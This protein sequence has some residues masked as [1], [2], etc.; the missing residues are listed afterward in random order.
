MRVPIVPFALKCALD[1]FPRPQYDHFVDP[2][3]V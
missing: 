3:A 1:A 2:E